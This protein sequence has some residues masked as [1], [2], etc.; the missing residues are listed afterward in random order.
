MF[1]LYV[2]LLDFSFVKFIKNNTKYLKLVVIILVGY[3][4]IRLKIFWIEDEGV[5]INTVFERIF[6]DYLLVWSVRGFNILR[7]DV[8]T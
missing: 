1:L 6:G 8:S 7:K 4:F 5:L 2:C 3:W